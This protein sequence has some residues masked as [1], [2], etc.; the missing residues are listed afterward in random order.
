MSR[1]RRLL[2]PIGLLLFALAFAA[3]PGAA[4]RTLQV[5][6][7]KP[8]KQPS[9]AIK[10][11]KDGDTVQI[12][13]GEYFDCALVPVNNL[14]IEG[15]GPDASAVLTDKTCAGK[16]LLVTSGANITIRNLTLARARVPDRNGAGIRA[17]GKGL[18]IEHVKFINNEDGILAAAVPDG[19]ITIRDSE[20]TRNGHCDG[21]CAHGIYVNTL[22]LLH[23]EHSK[24]FETRQGHHIKSRALRT[25][26]IGCDIRDG[27]NGTASYEIEAPNGGSLVVRDSTIEKGPKAE[28]HTAIIMIG[29]EGVT[30]PT[31][32]ITVENNTVRNDGNFPTTFVYNITATEAKLKGNKLI[33]TIEPLHGDGTVQ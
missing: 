7:D 4:A 19:T 24:F 16:A 18:T 14:V 15:T 13:A 20:F 23:I 1:I 25:E 26:V 6:P 28:N 32:E 2:R 10:D 12:A 21:D 29:S 9:A 3:P 8:Y 31:R 30:Q 22:A 11:A 33:G 5:G 27:P 17:E